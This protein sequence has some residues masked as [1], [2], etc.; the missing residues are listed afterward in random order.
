[1]VWGTAAVTPRHWAQPGDTG[2]RPCGADPPPLP[3]L[4]GAQPGVPWHWNQPRQGR[5]P[6]T[7][8]AVLMAVGFPRAHKAEVWDVLTRGIACSRAQAAQALSIPGQRGKAPTPPC[9]RL[10]FHL[11]WAPVSP[12]A[13][14]QTWQWVRWGP[15]SMLACPHPRHQLA[16]PPGQ[17]PPPALHPNP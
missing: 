9:V 5:L 17:Q 14:G 16:H 1:M 7:C 3:S 10:L 4:R 2:T 6:A 11:L 15:G 8:P 13:A 12:I